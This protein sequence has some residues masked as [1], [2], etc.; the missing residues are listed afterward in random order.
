MRHRCLG[1]W[2][3]TLAA[4]A[5]SPPCFSAWTP[6]QT[7]GEPPH[8]LRYIAERPAQVAAEGNAVHVVW[9]S[10]HD[11][12]QLLRYTRSEDCGD[13]WSAAETLVEIQLRADKYQAERYG[14][15][16]NDVAIA[17]SGDDVHVAWLEERL[18]GSYKTR[19]HYLNSRDGGEMWSEKRKIS[20]ASQVGRF[21]PVLIASRGRHVHVAWRAHS[22]G[23]SRIVI[24]S[25]HDQGATWTRDR[26]GPIAAREGSWPALGLDPTSGLAPPVHISFAKF[27]ERRK[28]IFHRTSVDGASW[29]K[30]PGR[31][32]AE[33]PKPGE[34]HDGDLVWPV[35]VLPSGDSFGMVWGHGTAFKYG[36]VSHDLYYQKHRDGVWSEKSRINRRPGTAWYPA[37]A[38]AGDTIHAAWQDFGN[39]WVARSTD[40]GRTWRRSQLREHTEGDRNLAVG[41]AAV[42]D[43]FGRCS[44]TAHIVYGGGTD[45]QENPRKLRYRRWPMKLR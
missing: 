8:I 44:G 13:T 10:R 28:N 33:T 30:S 35:A 15:V 4:F 3:L 18:L 22:A 20:R 26:P 29:I 9:F 11:D 42:P 5:A 40:Q 34:Y 31:L 36:Y 24:A 38:K 6:A 32:R 21:G 25:S 19:T 12:K 14:E 23:R 43:G 17:A 45:F 37:V 1:V 27:P 7:L 16:P 2:I 39:L 41:L